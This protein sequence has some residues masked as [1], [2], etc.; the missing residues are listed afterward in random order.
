[1]VRVVWVQVPPACSARAV[2]L[3]GPLRVTAGAMPA[4]VGDA[5]GEVV[6]DGDGDIDVVGVGVVDDVAQCFPQH[7]FGMVGQWAGDHAQRS[8]QA[9][10]GAQSALTG[11]F[12]DDRGQCRAQREPVVLPA[13]QVEDG[14][15]DIGK[16]QSVREQSLD[17]VVVIH[18]HDHTAESSFGLGILYQQELQI[19]DEQAEHLNGQWQAAL[20]AARPLWR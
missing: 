11:L 13:V 17:D 18:A 20:K 14:G 12:G 2:R 1:M 10:R 15:A 7:C 9:H 19:G 8:G 3:C 16:V 6:A 4:V 5:D